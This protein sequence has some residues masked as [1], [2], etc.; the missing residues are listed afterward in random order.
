MRGVAVLL[1][2]DEF[3][4]RSCTTSFGPM[5]VWELDD[6]Q[7]TLQQKNGSRA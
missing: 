5:D 3:G 1:H 4:M 7:L 2:G 6:T